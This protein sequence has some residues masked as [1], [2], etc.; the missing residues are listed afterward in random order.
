[1][2]PM[3]YQGKYLFVPKK[4]RTSTARCE[5]RCRKEVVDMRGKTR[6]PV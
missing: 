3:T 6:F 5:R 1:M 2:S 4:Y